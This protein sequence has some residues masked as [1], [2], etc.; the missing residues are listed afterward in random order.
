MNRINTLKP[1]VD[2]FWLF[3]VASLMWSGVGIY[4][5]FLAFGW[6]RP[7]N[8][9]PVTLFIISGLFLAV[10]IYFVMFR[11][12]ADQNIIRIN[13]LTGEK[14]CIF[15]FQR[16]TSY[17]LILVMISL[18]IILRL[19]SPIPKPYLAILY[20]GIGSSLFLAS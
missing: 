12:F 10:G 5:D 3:V 13:G 4:L 17:P 8:L 7:L 6:L 11:R 2:K 19:Y 9:A 20:L 16:W 1:G 18:G 15:T 14:I